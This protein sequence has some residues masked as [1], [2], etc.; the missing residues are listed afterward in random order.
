MRIQKHIFFLVPFLLF[1][2]G[3]TKSMRPLN[4]PKAENIRSIVIEHQQRVASDDRILR[5]PV[6]IINDDKSIQEFIH[7]LNATNNN[8]SQPFDT[9]PG[10]LYFI[11]LND[12][13][14]Q[15][16]IRMWVGANWIAGRNLEDDAHGNRLRRLSEEESANLYR[17]LKIP[18]ERA[19]KHDF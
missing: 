5:E 1:C 16:L 11:T 2:F 6:V 8:W 3:C 17:L 12:S 10:G 7:F 18:K 9:F 19:D 4:I 13:A 14:N 15:P